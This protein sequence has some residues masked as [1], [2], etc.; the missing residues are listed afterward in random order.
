MIVAGEAPLWTLI[1]GSAWKQE[2]STECHS[3]LAGEVTFQALRVPCQDHNQQWE[4]SPPCALPRSGCLSAVTKP[5]PL[6]CILCVL[7][8]IILSLVSRSALAYTQRDIR[9]DLLGTT[10]AIQTAVMAFACAVLPALAAP[11]PF[12][13]DAHLSTPGRAMSPVQTMLWAVPALQTAQLLQENIS[14]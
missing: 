14:A 11:P 12:S 8:T 5:S 2:Q 7:H 6:Q 13:Q 10:G 1:S 4:L 3:L 9:E